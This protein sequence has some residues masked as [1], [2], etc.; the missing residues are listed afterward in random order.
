MRGQRPL[1]PQQRQPLAGLPAHERVGVVREQHQQLGVGQAVVELHRRR[2]AAQQ[3]GHR[4]LVDAVEGP[5]RAGRIEHQ[6]RLGHGLAAC[7]QAQRKRRA[8]AAEQAQRE[9]DDEGLLLGLPRGRCAGLLEGQGVAARGG[10][11]DAARAHRRRAGL[12]VPALEGVQA[13]RERAVG[14]GVG[15][16]LH[17]VVA[18]HGLAVVAPEI[19]RQGAREAR[20]AD[21]GR[22]HAHDLGALLVDGGGVEVVDLDVAVGPHR[23]RHRAGVLGELQLA[24]LPH[25]GDAAHCTG[26]RRRCT[27]VGR[28]GVGGHVGAELLVAPD[29]EPFL[30]RELEPVAAGHAVAAPVVEVFVADDTLDAVVVVVGR[31]GRAGQ[32][33]ARVEQVEALVL[34]RAHVE[35]VD[36]DDHEALEVQRQAEAR[37][38]PGHRRDQRAQRVL[39]LAEV[40]AAHP[41]LQ[42]VLAAGAAADALLARDEVGGDQRE[43]VARLGVRVVPLRVVPAAVEIA[44][45]DQVAVGQQHRVARLVGAQRDGVDRHHVGAV[46]EAGDAP[47]A[48]GLALRVQA[49]AAGVEPAERGVALGRN[50]VADLERELRRSR[51]LVDDQLA[52]VVAKAHALAVGQHAQQCDLLGMQAQRLRRGVGRAFDAQPAADQGPGRVEVEAELDRADAVR[53]RRVV[54]APDGDGGAFTHRVLRG[55][56]LTGPA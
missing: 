18:G 5:C 49:A 47:E 32:H 41:D 12:R 33:V 53:W 19:Q 48:F 46:D 2:E 20:A 6:Q 43:Q 25:V 14:V 45:V 24:Q 50:G 52:A 39:G 44:A 34:H 22:G 31:G 9:R 27:A 13:Q 38:V 16:G 36:R 56:G 51:R 55:V 21:Q 11:E 3:R 42:Q 28:R 29:G 10:I 17:E 4:R 54:A 1:H 23:V 7:G 15:D 26:G 30:Q 37:L 40:A 35:V 8:V